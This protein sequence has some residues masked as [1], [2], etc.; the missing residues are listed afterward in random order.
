MNKHIP[1]LRKFSIVGLAVLLGG[2]V[3]AP[4]QREYVATAP[5]PPPPRL[6][7]Y[8]AQGQSAQQL[9]KDRYQ[10]HLWAVQQ[11]GFDPSRAGV[12]PSERVVVQ[13]GTPPGANTAVGAIAG[14]I[15]GA[16]IA[17]PG[18]AGA[19]LVLGGVTGAAI[20]ASNDAAAQAQ[21]RAEQQQ[22][23]QNYAQANQAN[24]IGMNNYRRAV[25]ACLVGRGYTVN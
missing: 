17:G 20:G 13:P 25:T 15:L 4:P 8:P 14:A 21:A 9:D 11:T 12:P 1:D 22:L 18:D 2:C 23:N 5:P 10:C 7:V 3:M 16:A 19:G 24:E 6:V